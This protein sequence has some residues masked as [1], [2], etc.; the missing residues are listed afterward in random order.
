[1]RLIE[2]GARVLVVDDDSSTRRM[3]SK[4]L[5]RYECVCTE[6]PD[7]PTA[8]KIAP[9]QEFDLV[10]CDIKMPRGSG[11]ELV[12]D[13]RSRHPDLAVLM[14]SGVDD[15]EIAAVAA[16]FGAY[17][18][19]VKPF[20]PNEILI[21][22]GN[23]LRRRHL[24]MANSAHRRDLEQL[25]AGMHAD[26]AS[27]V[28]RL[29]HTEHALRESQEEAIKR[30]AFAAEFHDPTTGSHINRMSRTSE[31]IASQA[32]LGQAKAE[33]IRIASPMH[34]I[35]KIGVPD[36][37][38]RKAGKLTEDEMNQMRKH[39]EIGNEIL[40]GSGSGTELLS[41]G[42]SIALTHHERWDGNGYP[43]RLAGDKIP[44]EGRIVA[45]A[46]VFD[47]LTSERSYKPAFDTDHAI[48]IMI[49]ERGRHFDPDLLDIFLNS[50][51]DSV[52]LALTG[53]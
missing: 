19:I 27:T 38:L 49:E 34:D 22:A 25:V 30:L 10:T 33:L 47:A 28:E 48:A 18:Y 9:D 7:A 11:L 44:V 50:M 29:L 23:S 42:A 8:L 41:L 14:V 39:P 26:L 17:G 20:G 53:A 1:M 2:A 36:E 31:L 6:A 5:E 37:I 51:D 52:G 35:G 45:I 21:A 3:I 13:L 24:E 46:D 40:G 12:A 32:G 15:P 16:D 4:M 43:H